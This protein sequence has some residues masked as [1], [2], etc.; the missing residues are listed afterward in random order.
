MKESELGKFV[1][2]RENQN[3]KKK[4]KL[5]WINSNSDEANKKQGE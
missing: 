3:V 5:I 2:Q 1:K 4:L